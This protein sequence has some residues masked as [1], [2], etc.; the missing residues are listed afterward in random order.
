MDRDAFGSMIKGAYAARA[1]GDLD[2]LMAIF[3]EN[4]VFSINGAGTG[5]DILAKPARG[6]QAVASVIGEL[7][8]TWRFDNWRERSLVVDGDRAVLHWSADVTCIPT[9]QSAH[10]DVV[11]VFTLKDGKVAEFRQFADTAHVLAMAGAPQVS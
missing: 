9:G 2:G 8:Q 5:V 3:H 6:R 10:L 1:R 7:M 11:D 4:G